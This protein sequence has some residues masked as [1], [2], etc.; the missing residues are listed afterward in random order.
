[1]PYSL[2]GWPVIASQ[3]SPLLRVGTIPGTR[4]RIRAHRDALP[5]LLAVAAA[6]N[7]EVAPL[8]LGNTTTSQDEAGYTYRVARGSS[9]WSNHAS[10]TAVDLNWKRRPAL[11]RRMSARERAAAERIARRVAPVI[12]WGGKWRTKPDEMHWEIRPGTTA[13]ELRAWTA[14]NVAPEGRLRT[15]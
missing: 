10:G 15:M 3:S 2:N 4:I 7:E 6:V 14:R 11:V 5:A 12:A 13:A 9:S 1:M 8:R